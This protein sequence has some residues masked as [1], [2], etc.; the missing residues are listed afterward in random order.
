MKSLCNVLRAVFEIHC[1]HLLSKRYQGPGTF[2]EA[3]EA[4]GEVFVGHHTT[5]TA[6]YAQVKNTTNTDILHMDLRNTNHAKL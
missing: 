3:C 2:L 4:Q 1:T 5:N 6:T